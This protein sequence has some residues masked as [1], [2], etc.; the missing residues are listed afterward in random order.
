V[1][2]QTSPDLLKLVARVESLSEVETQGRPMTIK[3]M[4]PDDDY[5][6]LPWYLRR[7]KEVGW[8][9]KVPENPYAPV[10][11]ASA[12]LE[13]KLDEKKT[14]LMVR[15]FVLRPQVFLELYVEKQLWQDWLATHPPKLD[16]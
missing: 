5:W 15:Y 6:P 7:F 2:A 11:I 12:K 4:A 16:E 1:Y 13:A 14:H 9:D 3:V 10:M 8:W